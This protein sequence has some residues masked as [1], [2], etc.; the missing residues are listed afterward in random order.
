MKWFKKDNTY[1][2]I[3]DCDICKECHRCKYCGKKPTIYDTKY[4]RWTREDLIDMIE[5]TKKI[6][7]EE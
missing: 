6:M 2:S 7:E 3:V 1:C 4:S 5:Q